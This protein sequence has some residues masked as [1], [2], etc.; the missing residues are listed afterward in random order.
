[1]SSQPREKPAI[2][3]TVTPTMIVMKVPTNE[4]SRETRDP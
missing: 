2:T 1:M 4:I 3:P